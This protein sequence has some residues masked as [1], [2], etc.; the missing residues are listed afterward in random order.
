LIYA[1]KWLVERYKGKNKYLGSMK[2]VIET[3]WRP[4][5]NLLFNF[6]HLNQF[7]DELIN[8][9]YK[10]TTKNI[11]DKFSML[12]EKYKVVTVNSITWLVKDIYKHNYLFERRYLTIMNESVVLDIE[13]GRWTDLPY[14]SKK[15][16]KSDIIE[17]WNQAEKAFMKNFEIE[18]TEEFLS[19]QKEFWQ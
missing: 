13:F 5:K 19:F 9:F 17:N 1:N 18:L 16:S 11:N 3:Y 15:I 7:S 10:L 14:Y 12:N 8:S 2:V 6:I 4:N